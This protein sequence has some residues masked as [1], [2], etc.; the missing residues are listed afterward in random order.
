[1]ENPTGAVTEPAAAATGTPAPAKRQR[2]SRAAAPARPPKQER[3]PLTIFQRLRDAA[4]RR[5][6][7]SNLDAADVRKLCSFSMIVEQA[8]DD[9]AA[10]MSSND[11]D[12][13]GSSL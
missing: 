10:A 7:V 11:D 5:T 8:T 1:M 12:G 13:P 6:G 9:D 2:R 4:V 3:A